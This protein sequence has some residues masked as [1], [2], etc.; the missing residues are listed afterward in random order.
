MNRIKFIEL[1]HSK[2]VCYTADDVIKFIAKSEGVPIGIANTL[3][4]SGELIDISYFIIHTYIIAKSFSELVVLEHV[5]GGRIVVRSRYF[6]AKQIVA[7][8]TRKTFAV[9]RSKK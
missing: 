4:M 2:I 5:G 1:P 9:K 3:I 7:L 6:A 8:S